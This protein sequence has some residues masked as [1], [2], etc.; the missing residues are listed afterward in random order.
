M[1]NCTIAGI[2]LGDSASLAAIIPEAIGSRGSKYRFFSAVKA[3]TSIDFII[4]LLNPN[5]ASGEHHVHSKSLSIY[6]AFKGTATL[7]LN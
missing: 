6:Y 4:N 1:S 7:A 2:D 3:R 5:S